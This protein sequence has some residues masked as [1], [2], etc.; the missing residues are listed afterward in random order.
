MRENHMRN[1]IRFKVLDDTT[2]RVDISSDT[3]IEI[4]DTLVKSLTARGMVEDA[5]RSTVSS[6]Y[7]FREQDRLVKMADAIIESLTSLSKASFL[8][9][10]RVIVDTRTSELDVPNKIPIDEPWT[11]RGSGIRYAYIRDLPKRDPPK[12]K[13]WWEKLNIF[14]EEEA[15]K[16]DNSKDS[17]AEQKSKEVSAKEEE[18]K[19][20]K[21]LAETIS[22]NS[23]MPRYL[24]PSTDELI[25]SAIAMGIG[26]D[27]RQLDAQGSLQGSSSYASSWIEE[28]TKP[29]G[30][31]FSSEEEEL[32]YWNSIKVSDSVDDD[33]TGY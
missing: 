24:N 4:V 12:K 18:D 30:Q 16:K 27:S 2:L 14:K 31:R 32:A 23:M 8:S 9:G 17:S 15:Q 6:R 11:A 21:K 20:A 28:A 22:A 3:P 33:S 7:F 26:T 19:L 25:K 5:S 29:I 1:K 13:K 10:K